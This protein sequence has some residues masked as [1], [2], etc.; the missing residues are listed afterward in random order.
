M[1]PTLGRR[2]FRGEIILGLNLRGYMCKL[3][4]L[5]NLNVFHIHSWHLQSLG[6]DAFHQSHFQ[7]YQCTPVRLTWLHPHW[8]A[9]LISLEPLQIP[10]HTS[11]APCSVLTSAAFTSSMNLRAYFYSFPL[12]LFLHYYFLL[13]LPLWYT[14]EKCKPITTWSLRK[15]LFGAMSH[16]I[17]AGFQPRTLFTD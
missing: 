7:S 1:A 5:L 16:D 13:S 8:D 15:C 4:V 11:S 6:T 2:K 3:K 10:L 9:V 14:S 12:S 17:R